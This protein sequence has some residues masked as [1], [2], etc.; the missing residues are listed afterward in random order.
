MKEDTFNSIIYNVLIVVFGLLVFFV[1]Y[2]LGKSEVKN[3]NIKTI[4]DTII[5][6]T[7]DTI[8]VDT[9][10]YKNKYKL[11]TL[12]VHDTILI[13]EQKVYQD[14][15]STI[16]ISGIEPDIDS[17]QY[18]IPKDTIIINNQ[19]TITKKKKLNFGI[20]VGGYLGAGVGYNP[21]NHN[22][23]LLAPEIGVGVIVG[24]IYSP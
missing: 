12:F 18:Y 7:T 14:S 10:I 4:T 24:V 15:F 19:T 20:G 2:D 8:K 22:F 3:E 17:I 13:K 9:I 21:I 1:G 16:W 11:D 23:G 6:H 5:I